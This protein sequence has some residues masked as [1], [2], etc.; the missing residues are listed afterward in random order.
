MRGKYSDGDR[1]SRQVLQPTR[2]TK[3]VGRSWVFRAISTLQ[4]NER[5]SY[6][7]F[8]GVFFAL[9]HLIVIGAGRY[10]TMG[11]LVAV[12]M[13]FCAALGLLLWNALSPKARVVPPQSK[14]NRPECADARPIVLERVSKVSL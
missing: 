9:P 13:S 5:L 11:R 10:E 2:L 1:S 8:I 3:A 4:K 7:V 12:G 14:L 6:W